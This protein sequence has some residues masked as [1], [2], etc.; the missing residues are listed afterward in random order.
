MPFGTIKR[1]AAAQ[2]DDRINLCSARQKHALLRS[3]ACRD[4]FRNRETRRLQYPRA[5]NGVRASATWPEATKPRS[6]T[7]RVAAE[8]EFTRQ[9]AEPFNR[10]GAEDQTRTWMEIESLHA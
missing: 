4:W 3:F 8:V 5:C 6:A 1:A 7:S 9:F 2:S 10:A